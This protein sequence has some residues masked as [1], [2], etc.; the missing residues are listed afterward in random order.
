MRVQHLGACCNVILRYSTVRDTGL[1]G[2]EWK[3]PPTSRGTFFEKGEGKFLLLVW[4][5]QRYLDE[6]LGGKYLL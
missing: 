3:P 6:L 2:T 4:V 5:D 1:L